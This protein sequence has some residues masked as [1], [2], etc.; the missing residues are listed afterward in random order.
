MPGFLYF[1]EKEIGPG[2]I[3][4]EV[5]GSLE[6]IER[7][8][9]PE[10]C[11]ATRCVGPNGKPGFTLYQDTV[12]VIQEIIPGSTHEWIDRG[13]FWIGW[14]KNNL[15][16]PESLERDKVTKNGYKL[17]DSSGRTWWIPVVRSELRGSTLPSD[18][19]FDANGEIRSVPKRQFQEYWELAGELFDYQCGN[20][21]G[22]TDAKTILAAAKMLG[23]NYR[24]TVHEL[25][26]LRQIG[27]PVLDTDFAHKVIMA[28]CDFPHYVMFKKKESSN[29][30]SPQGR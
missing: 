6:S 15:P 2:R 3:S 25:E 13:A 21:T 28:V 26:A 8:N 16:T 18:Y 30:E 4:Q 29:S 1:F 5:I 10:D 14:D 11:L 22:W 9:P 20:A 7:F 23:I 17:E 24:V 19:S 12:D 27:Y